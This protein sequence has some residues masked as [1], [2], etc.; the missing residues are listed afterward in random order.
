MKQ[1]S[2]CIFSGHENQ[3][4]DHANTAPTSESK[5]ECSPS[6]LPVFGPPSNLRKPNALA[7]GDRRESLLPQRRNLQKDRQSTKS[8]T[9]GGR[10]EVRESLPR[11]DR[12]AS[13]GVLPDMATEMES[14]QAA[15][16]FAET[17]TMMK[18]DATA[19]D[20]LE[21]SSNAQLRN[22]A[23]PRKTPR[24]L[25][26]P[27][28]A[29]RTPMGPP[30]NTSRSQSL[31]KPATF[32]GSSQGIDPTNQ[33]GP[34]G[35]AV[36][37]ASSKMRTQS[38][39][40]PRRKSFARNESGE[41]NSAEDIYTSTPLH[42]S[43]NVSVSS[44]MPTTQA[45]R[46]R[47]ASHK[48][49]P[50]HD[51]TH[52]VPSTLANAGRGASI[53]PAFSTLQ[54]HFSPKKTTRLQAES[55]IPASSMKQPCSTPISARLLCLQ[56]ELL[57]LHLM[58]MSSA[59]VQRQWEESAELSL[60]QRFEDVRA[61]HWR[62][63]IAKQKAQERINIEALQEWIKHDCKSNSPE[64]IQTLGASVQDLYGTVDIDSRFTQ[65]VRSFNRWIDSAQTIWQVRSEQRIGSRIDLGIIEGLGD[66][67][68]ADCAT[69]LRKVTTSMKDLEMLLVPNDGSSLATIMKVSRSLGACV[70]EELG[71]MQTTERQIVKDET[72]WVEKSISKIATAKLGVGHPHRNGVWQTS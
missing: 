25:A 65:L 52:V 61:V 53:R 4:S 24:A 48:V 21:V 27:K 47:L 63:H 20:E 41:T 22:E 49:E 69:I 67:W 50:Q 68:K 15:S 66:G 8:T 16:A 17:I 36:H 28:P 70:I 7:G 72:A 62:S 2:K 1:K 39:L 59:K 29:E 71:V 60:K 54:Q 55:V 31:R 46:L 51:Y 44:R 38:K 13:S 14:Q 3:P 23:S 33:T 6:R 45:P 5:T 34:K 58:H 40:L 32:A 30:W 18:D 12:D 11:S 56:T 42:E 64:R 43:R 19:I 37:L 9:T 35:A 57:Q 10:S 26:I